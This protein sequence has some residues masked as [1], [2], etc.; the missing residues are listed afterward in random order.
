MGPLLSPIQTGARAKVPSD[1]DTALERLCKELLYK[2]AWVKCWWNCNLRRVALRC[3]GVNLLVLGEWGP[4]FLEKFFSKLALVERSAKNET[5][6]EFLNRKFSN[7]G[8]HSYNTWHFPDPLPPVVFYF[9]NAC[10]LRL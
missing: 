2:K 7:L 9:F 8:G 1:P 6:L 3:R 4:D 10:F 5:L